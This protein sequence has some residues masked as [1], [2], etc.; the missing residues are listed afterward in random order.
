MA[1]DYSR[2]CQLVQSA[3]DGRPG[4]TLALIAAQLGIERHTITNAFRV[5][6][7]ES[8]RD[9]R[10]AT[11]VNKARCLLS[12]DGTRSIKEISYSLGFASPRSFQRAIV[13][14]FR[15]TPT[16]IRNSQNSLPARN[17]GILHEAYLKETYPIA[18]GILHLRFQL[19]RAHGFQFESGQSVALLV[20]FDH[21]HVIRLYSVAS[22]PTLL[23]TGDFDLCVKVIDKGSV[24]SWLGQLRV[25]DLVKFLGPFGL[26]TLRPVLDSTLVFVAMGVG[27]APIR[28]ML[29]YLFEKRTKHLSGAETWLFLG[30]RTEE[31][32]LYRE[33]FE[34]MAQD[35][36]NFRFVPVL[37]NPGPNW[38]GHRGR[39]QAWIDRYLSDKH[40]LRVYVCGCEA[41]IRDVQS[42]MEEMGHSSSTLVHNLDG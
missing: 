41:L 15:M 39:I 35:Q 13:K 38:S 8:F 29:Q 26:F 37:S 27:I 14:A 42:T 10:Q 6:T 22:S 3:L 30:A 11:I 24:T 32:I 33:E 28:S 9:F 20:P 40:Q 4:A 2:I 17:Q 16:Q 36:S 1:Y 18:S 31:T 19:A 23:E 34:A 25:G 21:K 5:T 7:G 12:A